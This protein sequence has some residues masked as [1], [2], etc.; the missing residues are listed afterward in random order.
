MLCLEVVRIICT[1]I[2]QWRRNNNN[3]KN[4]IPRNTIVLASIE[5]LSLSESTRR[6]LDLQTTNC[7]HA[8][9][10]EVF[11]TEGSNVRLRTRIISIESY[12]AV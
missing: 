6:F 9:V 8:A 1:T 12:H 7:I 4:T 5:S 3:A 2:P 11:T 10:L